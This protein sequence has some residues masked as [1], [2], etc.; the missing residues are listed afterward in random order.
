VAEGV[1]GDLLGDLGF[2]DGMIERALKLGFVKV[3]TAAFSGF[4]H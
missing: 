4:R 1:G 3:I 2:A